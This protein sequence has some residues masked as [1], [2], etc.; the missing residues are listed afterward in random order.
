MPPAYERV[1]LCP[2]PDGHI[3]GIGYD[4]KGR[5]QYRYHPDFRADQDSLKFDRLADFGRI[6]PK[7]RKQVERDIRGK[8]TSC[9]AVIAAVVRLIDA[10]HMRVGS[11]EYAKANKS[12][13]AT[14]CATATRRLPATSQISYPASTASGER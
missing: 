13:G 5:R 11:E 9:E 1:W 8:P 7:L 10:T 14:P 6:V 12:F 3:Q 2:D 4:D